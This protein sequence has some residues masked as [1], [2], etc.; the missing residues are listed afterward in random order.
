MADEDRF[1]PKAPLSEAVMRGIRRPTDTKLRQD[2]RMGRDPAARL[3]EDTSISLALDRAEPREIARGRQ[4]TVGA[5]I[6]DEAAYRR[7]M[8]RRQRREARSRNR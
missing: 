5:A 3:K 6:G 8:S 2:V 4:Q 7:P 1:Y